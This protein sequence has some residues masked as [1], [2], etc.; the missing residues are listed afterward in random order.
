MTGNKFG[1]RTLAQSWILPIV[2]ISGLASA[3]AIPWN[4]TNV[5]AFD[6]A[7][8]LVPLIAQFALACTTS[9]FAFQGKSAW[10]GLMIATTI[11]TLGNALLY[12]VNFWGVQLP[13]LPKALIVITALSL[14]PALIWGKKTVQYSAPNSQGFE[15][16]N[17]GDW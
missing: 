14:I 4:Y 8:T 12:G 7:A 17:G 15:T 13:N 1:D 11:L 9:V 10:L 2:I 6:I 16:T 3:Y 5:S